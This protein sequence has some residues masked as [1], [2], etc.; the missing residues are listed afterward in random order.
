MRSAPCACPMWYDS[1][2]VIAVSPWLFFRVFVSR[3]LV[4]VMCVYLSN[5]CEVELA[6]CV[7]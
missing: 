4:D 3:D 6:C 2:L 5:Q 1:S 7:S